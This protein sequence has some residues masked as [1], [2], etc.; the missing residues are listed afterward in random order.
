VSDVKKNGASFSDVRYQMDAYDPS[1]NN[2]FLKKMFLLND[3]DL[4]FFA[5]KILKPS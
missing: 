3:L 5:K 1:E 2:Y 4:L